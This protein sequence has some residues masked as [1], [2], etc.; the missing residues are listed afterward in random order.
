M[1]NTSSGELKH[2]GPRRKW[3]CPV[4]DHAADDPQAV[5]AFLHIVS[6]RHEPIEASSGGLSRRGRAA[7]SHHRRAADRARGQISASIAWEGARR[8]GE[9]MKMVQS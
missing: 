4:S 9:G 7:S 5:Q 1:W 8:M 2:P 3:K 6:T